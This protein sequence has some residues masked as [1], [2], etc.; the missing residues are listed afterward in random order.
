M[1]EKARQGLD[2]GIVTVLYSP[3]VVLSSSS[4]PCGISKVC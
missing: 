1:W 4:V 3:S 2:C